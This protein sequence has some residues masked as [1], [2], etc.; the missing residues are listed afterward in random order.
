MKMSELIE[1]LTMQLETNGDD[2]FNHATI[3]EHEITFVNENNE[4]TVLTLA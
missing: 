3:E 4:L 1:I 2:E